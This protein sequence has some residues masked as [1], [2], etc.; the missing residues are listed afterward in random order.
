[1]FG[2]YTYF[3][4]SYFYLQNSVEMRRNRTVF[5][6]FDHRQWKTNQIQQEYANKKMFW[7]ICDNAQIN[8]REGDATSFFFW[9]VGKESCI[10]G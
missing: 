4:P 8:V 9:G 6:A 2:W 1:M 3:T 7:T 10:M 5:K